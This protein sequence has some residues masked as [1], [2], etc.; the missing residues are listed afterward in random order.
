AGEMRLGA[1]PH[2]SDREMHRKRRS[3]STPANNLAADADDLLPAGPKVIG[4]VAVVL[5]LIR[6]RHQQVDALSDD[7]GRGITEHPLR[8]S[9][10]D[11]DEP[12][13]VDDDDP[14]DGR[15]DDRSPAFFADEKS[16]VPTQ[17]VIWHQRRQAYSRFGPSLAKRQE[18]RE[19]VR[20]TTD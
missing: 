18:G 20:D 10:K 9:V 4:D 14:V 16:V 17:A 5:L 2:L 13:A 12:V 7:L 3:V 1:D 15:I 11:F 19:G 6:R 8:R